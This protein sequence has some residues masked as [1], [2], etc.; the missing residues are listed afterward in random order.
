MASQTKSDLVGDSVILVGTNVKVKGK[1]NVKAKVNVKVES[2][3][4]VKAE[5]KV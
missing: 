3:V 5:V 1:V 2:K 4:D